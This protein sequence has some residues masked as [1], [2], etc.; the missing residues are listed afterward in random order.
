V[1]YIPYRDNNCC[2]I[3]PW[4][5]VGVASLGTILLCAQSTPS[6]LADGAASG[7]HP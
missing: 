1:F 3:V 7:S 4:I 6:V 5:L 2:G